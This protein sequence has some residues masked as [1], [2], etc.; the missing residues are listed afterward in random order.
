MRRIRK[1]E[2]LNARKPFDVEAREAGSRLT[3]N[4]FVCHSFAARE[5]N[6]PRGRGG[7]EA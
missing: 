6:T 3:L 2:R 7:K 1:G 4:R 5:G